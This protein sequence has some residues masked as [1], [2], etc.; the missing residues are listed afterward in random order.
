MLR[1][2]IFGALVYLAVSPALQ[3]SA[4]AQP[5]KKLIAH[6]WN[7]PVTEELRRELD[8][9]E[10]SPFDG[11]VF[12]AFLKEGSG[13]RRVL[14][15]N[16]FTNKRLAYNEFASSVRDLRKTRFKRLT[17]NFI[18]VA[19]IPGRG[20][21]WF[22]NFDDAIHNMRLVGRFIRDSRIRGIYLDL[23][24]YQFDIWKYAA[25]RKRGTKSLQ[26]Y[27]THVFEEGGKLIQALQQGVG[28]PFVLF[29]PF[30][31]ELTVPRGSHEAS[32][33]RYGLLRAFLDGVIQ[34]ANPQVSIISGYTW[35]YGAK[36]Q[37]D[38]TRGFYDT[39]VLNEQASA[40]PTQYRERTL[41]GFGLWL[42]FFWKR[43]GWNTSRFKQN[44]FSP[45]EFRTAVTYALQRS[46]KYVWIY[47]QKVN[48]FKGSGFPRAYRIGLSKARKNAG[49]VR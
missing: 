45:T 18:R 24:P 46:D 9:Y 36:T 12:N 48:F 5:W 20:I 37:N 6:G 8:L 41:A 34:Q 3:S 25:Q 10:K 23:E 28:R 16:V 29:L 49:L 43:N 30:T 26:E 27:D 4:A 17:E 47:E 40:F 1:H 32:H 7:L 2:F 21:D 19:V 31:Y 14:S 44:Y 22:T 33:H 42:D 15:Q 35:S 39:K 13:R 38:F 11:T